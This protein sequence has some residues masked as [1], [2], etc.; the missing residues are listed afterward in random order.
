MSE[1]YLNIKAFTLQPK[2]LSKLIEK[3]HSGKSESDKIN[4]LEGKIEVIGQDIKE[5]K[6]MLG[7]FLSKYN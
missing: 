7:G 1:K 6:E 4:I 3:D 2:A 5:L